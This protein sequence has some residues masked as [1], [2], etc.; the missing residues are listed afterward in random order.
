[1]IKS[2]KCLTK[3]LYMLELAYYRKWKGWGG[4]F[5]WTGL[6]TQQ[7][8]SQLLAVTSSGPWSPSR[9]VPGSQFFNSS[10]NGPGWRRSGTTKYFVAWYNGFEL[11]SYIVL[12]KCQTLI[13][14]PIDELFKRIYLQLFNEDCLPVTNTKNTLYGSKP[15]EEED[16]WHLTCAIWHMAHDT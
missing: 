11:R 13:L 7:L 9:Q 6:S 4:G 5:A 10:R 14:Y 2:F 12:A 1:M 15:S 8:F 16:I 3:E